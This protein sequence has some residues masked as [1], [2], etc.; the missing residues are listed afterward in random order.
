MLEVRSLRQLSLGRDQLGGDHRADGPA[1][2]VDGERRARPQ[3]RAAAAASSAA[4]R[5]RRR[6]G[7]C[8][9][10][11]SPT[12]AHRRRSRRARAIRSRCLGVAVLQPADEVKGAPWYLPATP[13]CRACGRRRARRSRRSCAAGHRRERPSSGRSC[14]LRTATPPSG[15]RPAHRSWA[16]G[17]IGALGRGV[18][19]GQSMRVYEGGAARTLLPTSHHIKRAS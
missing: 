17:A 13:S 12:S 1:L 4:R 16:R 18:G 14:R 19:G 10:K 8:L 2:A 11:A 5:R 15:T 6:S 9:R 7:R 3:A